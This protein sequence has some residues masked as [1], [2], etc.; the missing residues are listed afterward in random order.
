MANYNRINLANNQREIDEQLSDAEVLP[1]VIN[2]SAKAFFNSCIGIPY[3][4]NFLDF[5]RKRLL[6]LD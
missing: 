5:Y 4:G 1:I 6:F 3:S 2:E